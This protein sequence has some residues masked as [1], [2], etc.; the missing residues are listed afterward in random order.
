MSAFDKAW[1]LLKM[2][3]SLNRFGRYLPFGH[4]SILTRL[5]QESNEDFREHA[6]FSEY[7]DDPAIQRRVKEH[8]KGD[9][10]VENPE[11]TKVLSSVYGNRRSLDEYG[12]SGRPLNFSTQQAMGA[13][14]D[15][16]FAYYQPP[17]M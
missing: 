5:P 1:Q 2:T 6:Q 14:D 13:S 9:E 7:R 4:S 16:A 12:D 11:N 17:Q 10:I 8:F 3:K 15:S